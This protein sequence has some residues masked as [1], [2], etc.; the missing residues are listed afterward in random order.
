MNKDDFRIGLEFYTATGRWRCTDVGTRVIAAI[1]LN[2]FDVHGGVAVL[3][4]EMPPILTRDGPG[5][6]RANTNTAAG[7]T[8]GERRSETR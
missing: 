4:P 3:L 6:K 7:N 1:Q 8:N 2:H 5:G